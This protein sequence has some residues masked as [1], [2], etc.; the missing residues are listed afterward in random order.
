MI[1][2]VMPAIGA[3]IDRLGTHWRQRVP[4]VARLAADL[5][6]VAVIVAAA[7]LALGA[8]GDPLPIRL[9]LV[10]LALAPWL[11]AGLPAVPGWVAAATLLPTALLFW[12]GDQFAAMFAMLLV[13]DVAADGRRVLIALTVLAGLAVVVPPYVVHRQSSW[14]YWV[15]GLLISVFGGWAFHT[16]RRLQDQ[17]AEARAALDR[18]AFMEERRRIASDV[19]DLLAHS[20]T[21]VMLHLTAARMAVERDPAGAGTTLAEAEQLGRQALGEVRRLVDLLRG[22]DRPDAAAPLP[23]ARDLPGLVARLSAAGMT[24]QLEV[25]GDETRLSPSTG[26]ALFRIAQEALSNA[27]RHAPGARVE[28]RLTVEAREARLS[29]RN[30]A[31]VGGLDRSP[32]RGSGHGLAGMLER[33]ALLGGT[34]RAAPANPGWVVECVIPA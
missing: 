27:G 30:W 18:Q 3:V 31:A 11:A 5:R 34:L 1:W 23:S 12:R 10:A 4:S 8:S 28:V 16:Q 13:I 2:S 20:L 21:V 19:H 6:T 15:G 26:L 17:L 25:E 14:A 29:V 22:D 33:A 7:T 9:V 24:V 32:R